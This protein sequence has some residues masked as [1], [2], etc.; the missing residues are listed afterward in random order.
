[1]RVDKESMKAGRMAVENHIVVD[2]KAIKN[3]DE[4]PVAPVRPQLK[5]VAK[6]SS[7]VYY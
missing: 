7:T 2:L 5:A 3:L 1:M 4:I 6:V